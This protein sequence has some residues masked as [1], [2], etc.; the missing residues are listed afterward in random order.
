[1][2]ETQRIAREWLVDRLDSVDARLNAAGHKIYFAEFTLR[3]SD[4]HR[5]P[6]FHD[7]TGRTDT[8]LHRLQHRLDAAFPDDT[9]PQVKATRYDTR[10]LTVVMQ[11]N[12]HAG[13]T[14]KALKERNGPDRAC[15]K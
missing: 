5:T 7:Q 13:Q 6:G 11:V 10:T 9:P 4:A 8:L 2:T 1:M 15:G 14:L 12:A 3:R